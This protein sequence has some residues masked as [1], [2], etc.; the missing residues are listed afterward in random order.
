MSD[1]SNAFGRNTS[2]ASDY[3]A[4]LMGLVGDREPLAVLSELVGAIE[5]VSAGLDAETLSRPERTGKWSMAAVVAHLADA[6]LVQSYRL[7]LVLAQ[8]GIVITGYDQDAWASEFRYD[9]VPV[10]D[11]LRRIALLRDENLTLI[12]G[13]KGD[14]LER[15]GLHNERGR[16]SV[17]HMLRLMAGHDLVHRRQLARVRA[18]VTQGHA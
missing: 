12:T 1:F 17:S 8:P 18:A 2:A 16:E 6:E 11:S 7:R 9:Q 15:F 5:E 4:A 10:S 3:V 14:A 13:L